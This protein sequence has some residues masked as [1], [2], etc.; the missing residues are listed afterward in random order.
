MKRALELLLVLIAV[1]AGALLFLPRLRAGAAL[2]AAPSFSGT[3]YHAGKAPL[4]PSPGRCGGTGCHEG[5]PHAGGGGM[6]AFR[7]LHGG[8]VECLA[9]HGVSGKGG[10]IS[11]GSA[12]SLLASRDT[13]GKEGERHAGVARGALGCR[14]CHSRD[15]EQAIRR[16]GVPALTAAFADPMALRMV[17]SG[18]RKW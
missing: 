15:G 17:E 12:G 9:C 5:A 10:W 14:E 6:A 3:T 7:N 18:A 13:G 2:P 16:A 4:P 11:G 1:A 8:K